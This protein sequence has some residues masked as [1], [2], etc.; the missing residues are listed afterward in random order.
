M[1]GGKPRP[2]IGHSYVTPERG[3]TIESPQL[4]FQQIVETELR[5]LLEEYWFDNPGK[6][7][8]MTKRLLEGL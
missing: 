8:A 7:E 4:W 3:A 2:K 6:A 5:P 1:P